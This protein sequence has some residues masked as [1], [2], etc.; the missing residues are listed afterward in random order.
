MGAFKLGAVIAVLFVVAVINDWS[1]P[2]RLIVMLLAILAVSYVWS[3]LSLQRLAMTRSL[4]LD[5]VRAGEWVTEAVTISNHG[6]LPKLWIEVRD[7]SSLPGHNPGRVVNLGALGS[8]QWETRTKCRHRGRFRLGPMTV[9]SGDPLGL[10]RV[11][12][13]VPVT[14]ALIVYP[15]AL[16][17]SRVPL[18]AASMSGGKAVNRNALVAAHTIAGV[19][20]YATGDPLNRISWTATARTGTMMVKEFDPD[21]TSDLWIMLDLGGS[22]WSGRNT[23]SVGT[24]GNA[25]AA[26]AA[27]ATREVTPGL[28]V[29]LP[30][31]AEEHAIAL[32]GSVA[33]RALAEGRK[34][35]LIVN[36]AMPVRIDPASS[37]RQ[38]FRIFETLAIA[39]PFGERSLLEAISA[40][41]SKFSRNAGL[42]VVTASSSRDWVSA[43]E[44]LV[45]RQVPVTAVVIDSEEP[46]RQ[47]SSMALLLESI[48]AARVELAVFRSDHRIDTGGES[49]D[50]HDA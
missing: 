8:A 19:R 26:R 31:T 33:E 37:Q 3:R 11:H 50:A 4:S 21:P 22:H 41:A 44:A 29:A 42:V 35:G 38:W 43:A 30:R 36:R 34:V 45:H 27:P 20:E 24:P 46:D 2:D 40:E 12:K 15:M 17:V 23:G 1:A 25:R 6:R 13:S 7:H 39:T 32:A 28:E 16:D 47:S 10:F 14:H 49:D 18:P 48:T 9:S 5:R